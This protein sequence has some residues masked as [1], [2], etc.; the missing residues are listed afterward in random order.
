M[1]PGA[2]EVLLLIRGRT[3]FIRAAAF[4]I[5]RV[6]L[7]RIMLFPSVTTPHASA[8][9]YRY[10]CFAVFNGYLCPHIFQV[11]SWIAIKLLVFLSWLCC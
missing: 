10:C 8:K 5:R 2:A 9:P 6:I 11:Y 4:P 1:R 3:S 7:R